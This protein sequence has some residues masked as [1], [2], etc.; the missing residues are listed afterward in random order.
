MLQS[1]VL[2]FKYSNAAK[3]Y[4]KADTLYPYLCRDSFI[5]DNVKFIVKRKNGFVITGDVV[6]I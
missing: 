6:S 3:G 1:L 2:E 5:S 4:V